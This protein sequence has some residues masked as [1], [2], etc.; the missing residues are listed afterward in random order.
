[1]TSFGMGVGK[2]VT[3][4]DCDIRLFLSHYWVH[5]EMH[6]GSQT[7]GSWLVVWIGFFHSTNTMILIF[8]GVFVWNLPS[9]KKNPRPRIHDAI[10]SRREP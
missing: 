6:F 3:L 8:G 9:S 5:V 10:E 7:N 1:M 2:L 4:H